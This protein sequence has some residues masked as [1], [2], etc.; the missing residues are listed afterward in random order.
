LNITELTDKIQEQADLID[1]EDQ[2]LTPESS[3]PSTS[4]EHSS[5]D[6]LIKK[7]VESMLSI[8]GCHRDVIKGESYHSIDIRK[9]EDVIQVEE[10]EDFYSSS[11]E[12]EEE[13]D[14]PAS[15]GG[16]RSHAFQT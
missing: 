5:T 3:P 15:P 10:E 2:Q 14:L 13:A 4:E 16:N 8:N 7:Y 6:L 9:D 1:L 11:D 12:E